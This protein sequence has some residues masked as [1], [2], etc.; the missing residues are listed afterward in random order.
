M[1]E[2]PAQSRFRVQVEFSPQPD[3]EL[4]ASLLRREHEAEAE[5]SQASSPQRQGLSMHEAVK[6]SRKVMGMAKV[7][8]VRHWAARGRE[9]PS[10]VKGHRS[11]G[12][13]G[14]RGL[15]LTRPLT[16]SHGG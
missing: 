7:Q 10:A 6:G 4:R 1:G 11:E 14:C 16:A 8:E 5:H 2:I 3:P 12:A 15:H 9:R 13:G